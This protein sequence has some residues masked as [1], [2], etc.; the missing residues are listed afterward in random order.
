MREASL[1]GSSWISTPRCS[2]AEKYTSKNISI[3]KPYNLRLHITLIHSLL[4]PDN[5]ISSLLT[6]LE[7]YTSIDRLESTEESRLEIIFD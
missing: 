4:R 6:R 1:I 7:L 3:V 5:I 2:P